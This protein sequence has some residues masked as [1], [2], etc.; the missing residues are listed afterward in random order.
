MQ[1]PTPQDYNEAVQDPYLCFS[2][3]ELA[4]AEVRCDRF[5]MPRA[6]TGNFASIYRLNCADSS[7]AVRCFLYQ[8]ADRENRYRAISDCLREASLPFL[9]PFIYQA[10]GIKVS[11]KSFPIVKMKYLDAYTLK[12]YVSS[13]AGNKKAFAPLIK[14]IEMIAL[15]LKKHGIAHGDLQ[16]DNILVH[17]GNLFL[18]DYDAMFVPELSGLSCNELGHPSYQHPE[19]SATNFKQQMDNFSFWIIRNSLRIIAEDPCI[20]Y[21]SEDI[22]DGLLFSVADLQ[23]PSA[24]PLFAQLECHESELINEASRQIRALLALDANEMP[25]LCDFQVMLELLAQT[26]PLSA[27]AWTVF[28]E[29]QNSKPPRIAASK[30]RPSSSATTSLGTLTRSRQEISPPSY[31]KR[32][33]HRWPEAYEFE[34][35]YGYR[36]LAELIESRSTL[37]GEMPFI[38]PI[39]AARMEEHS[40]PIIMI[41]LTLFVCYFLC[42]IPHT[43]VLLLTAGS[44]ILLSRPKQL[45]QYFTCKTT[46]KNGPRGR[47]LARVSNLL[48]DGRCYLVSF[49]LGG[50]PYER[51]VVLESGVNENFHGKNFRICNKSEL[52]NLP[53]WNE[54]KTMS[55][56]LYLDAGHTDAPIAICA[57]GNVLIWL[58]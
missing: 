52:C 36:H 33:K 20:F 27:Q 14:Q 56:L 22:S 35:H 42:Q 9:L 47:F 50:T 5:G 34:V 18:V 51:S 46:L 44:L 40:V 45:I 24:S 2:D 53:L 1:W 49:S 3:A 58:I 26:K 17:E 37:P 48:S 12:N 54:A 55:G 15:E 28:C 8:I 7:W 41:M 21:Q 32:H 16:H 30:S 10:D 4:A 11:G 39:I 29:Q 19:K 13:I 57:E 43:L 38:P 6:E 31:G 23:N 25:A